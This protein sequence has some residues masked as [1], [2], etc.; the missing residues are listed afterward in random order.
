MKS[1]GKIHNATINDMIMAVASL[2]IKEYFVKNGDEKTTE[3]K[4]AMPISL[5]EMPKDITK[6][7]VNNSIV[8]LPITLPLCS[9]FKVA[10]PLISKDMNKMK[11]S[12]DPFVFIGIMKFINYFLPGFVAKQLF[13]DITNKMTMVFSN[14]PGPKTPFDF[15]GAKSDWMVYEGPSFAT[16]GMACYIISHTG[17]VKVLIKSD[18]SYLKH[19][20]DLL[21]IFEEKFD[22]LIKEGK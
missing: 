7:R 18:K 22:L 1:A 9:E 21:K 17:A 4:L 16:I 13:L 11:K 6:F 10:I 12:L 5:R 15:C 14:V 3:I 2:A 20:N 8:T 19:A